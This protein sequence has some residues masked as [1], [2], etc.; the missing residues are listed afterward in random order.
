M[1][2]TMAHCFFLSSSILFFFYS[3]LRQ[4]KEGAESRSRGAS[5]SSNRGGRGGSDRSVGR[6]GS[7]QFSS[8]GMCI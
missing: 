7:T 5:N 6:S 1:L 4:I 3:S 2:S 8:A